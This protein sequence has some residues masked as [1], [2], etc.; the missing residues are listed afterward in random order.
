MTDEIRMGCDCGNE[1]CYLCIAIDLD[2]GLLRV[3]GGD[4]GKP[5]APPVATV[6]FSEKNQRELMQALMEKFG[7]SD[8]LKQSEEP[9]KNL[10]PKK[11]DKDPPYWMRSGRHG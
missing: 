8:K 9:P 3:I 7:L 4:F 10:P 5:D 1:S 6:G 2:K 11:D